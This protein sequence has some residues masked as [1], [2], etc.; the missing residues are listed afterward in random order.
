MQ[1]NEIGWSV[2]E[3]AIAKTAFERAYEREISSLIN[4]VRKAASLIGSLDDVWQLHDFLSARRHN[5]DGRYD[6]DYT[7]LM[8]V[9]AGLLKEGWLSLQDLD[10]L[11]KDK[12]AKISS[13]SRM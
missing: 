6:F 8:F 9:F 1:V 12:L 5:I 7:S 10:G 4:E 2:G 3:Q 11:G 13:L